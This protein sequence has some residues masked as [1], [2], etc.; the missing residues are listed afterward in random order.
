MYEELKY[1]VW[2]SSLLQINPR[3][4]IELIEYFGKPQYI[5]HSKEDELREIPFIM[6]FFILTPGLTMPYILNFLIIY[7]YIY[8]QLH[9]LFLFY[10]YLHLS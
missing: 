6:V 2:M 9:C 7:C 10:L 5:W 3:K 4:R 8:L 1:W